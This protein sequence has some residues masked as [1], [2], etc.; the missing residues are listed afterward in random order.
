MFLITLIAYFKDR[1][2]LIITNI[3]VLWGPV[4]ILSYLSQ[5]AFSYLY[6]T[7]NYAYVS[8]I[9]FA[10]YLIL[11][12]AFAITFELKIA[13]QDIEFMAWRNNYGKSS[14][15][16][17]V[18]SGLLSFKLLRLHYSHLFGFDKFKAPFDKPG[19]F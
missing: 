17:Q 9:A 4:Q 6:G 15:A 8:G 11:N 14:K 2:S 1:R 12:V 7:M 18:F 19:V 13:R 3:I 16:I 5:T 10:T